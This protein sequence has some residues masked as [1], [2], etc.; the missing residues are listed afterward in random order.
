M[1]IVLAVLVTIVF[2]VV[3]IIVRKKRLFRKQSRVTVLNT[4]ENANIAGN[5][6]HLE[7][8]DVGADPR[9]S[10]DIQLPLGKDDDL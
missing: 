1:V 8:E 10:P 6:A 5:T 9:A 7:T 3:I 4:E 2:L